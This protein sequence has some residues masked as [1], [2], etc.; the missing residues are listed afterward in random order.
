MDA[1]FAK[2]ITRLIGSSLLWSYVVIAG[3][4]TAFEKE[5]SGQENALFG[6]EFLL[7]G[8]EIFSLV[9]KFSFGTR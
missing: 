6:Q 2:V 1:T 5:K 8:Q 4:R 3:V 7:F 9:R